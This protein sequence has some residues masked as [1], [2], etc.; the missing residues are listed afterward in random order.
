MRIRQFYI[1]RE[2]EFDMGIEGVLVWFFALMI[3]FFI[4]LKCG[5]A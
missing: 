3:G 5:K 4:G 2:K 1:M